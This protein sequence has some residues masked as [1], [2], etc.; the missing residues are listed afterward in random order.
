M[1]PQITTE[2]L[3]LRPCVAADGAQV[4]PLL[5]DY[6][7][8]KWLARV[9]HPFG[10]E[11]LRL[12]GEGGASRWPE[13]AAITL[14][15]DIIGGISMVPQHLGYWL[16][17]AYWHRGYGTEAVAAAL[18]FMFSS[19]AQDVVSAVFEG[20]DASHR[21]LQ[22]QGFRETRR[23]LAPCLARGEDIANVHYRLTRADWEAR[24]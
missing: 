24:I 1:T 19:G 18:R 11:D 21:I 8:S 9:P 3:V 7:V 23:D 17:A 15:G 6:A 14:D 16:G 10:A 2:R 4:V 12:V 5:N 22:R 13:L 20:N